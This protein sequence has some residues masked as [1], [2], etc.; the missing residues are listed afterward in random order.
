MAQDGKHTT[1]RSNIS[2]MKTAK[3]YVEGPQAKENFEHFASAILQVPKAG[4]RKTTKA[5]KKATARK[6]P[7]KGEG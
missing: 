2:S 4:A 7:G 1:Q 3:E 5:K 6:K